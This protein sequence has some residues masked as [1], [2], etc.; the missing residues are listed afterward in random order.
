M[1]SRGAIADERAVLEGNTQPFKLRV[2]KDKGAVQ[3]ENTAL[4]EATIYEENGSFIPQCSYLF[5]AVDNN[6]QPLTYV[7]LAEFKKAVDEYC[8]EVLATGYYVKSI[9]KASSL[10]SKAMQAFNF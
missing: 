7:N 5:E 2:T 4:L 6:D 8:T 1:I 3:G 10:C 9:P